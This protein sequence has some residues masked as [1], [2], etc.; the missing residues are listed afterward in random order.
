MVRVCLDLYNIV[1]TD[2]T[3]RSKHRWRLLNQDLTLE[4]LPFGLYVTLLNSAD[5]IHILSL[6]LLHHI[7]NMKNLIQG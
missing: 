5:C 4:N 6:L 2:G 7:T 3:L 1:E